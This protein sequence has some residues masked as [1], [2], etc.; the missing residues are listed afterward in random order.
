MKL[1]VA[2]VCGGASAEANVSRKSAAG[3]VTALQSAGHSVTRHELDAQLAARLVA[4]QPDVVFPITHGTLGEDGCLQGLLEVL[5]LPYV[6]CGVLA[7]AIAANKPLTKKLWLESNLPV[8]PDVIVARGDDIH[9]AAERA[10]EELGGALVI[11]PA[12]GGS[13]IGVY[14]LSAEC[15]LTDVVAGIEA[16]LR[17]DGHALIEPLLSG[18]EVTCGVLE[19]TPGFPVALPPTLIIPK[20]ADFYDFASKYAKGGSRHVCPAPLSGQVTAR[21]GNDA[22]AAHRAIGARDMSRVDFF[23]DESQ[24]PARITLLEINTLPGMTE[25]SLYPEAAAAFGLDF[26]TLCDQLVQVAHGRPRR[27]APEAMEI[28]GEG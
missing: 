18:V 6:G 15:A 3:V 7:S 21:I 23:V 26:P 9:A 5:N 12:E 2:V 11:K 19:S 13:A 10:R 4:E 28:P 24:T 8:A 20:L 22:V 27:E 14:R 25:T 1:R 17:M 16:V